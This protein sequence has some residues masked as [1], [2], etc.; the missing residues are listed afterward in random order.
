MKRSL[1]AL[2]LLL[3]VSAIASAQTGLEINEIFNGKYAGD[4]KVTQT[5]ISG[6]NKF[7]KAHDLTVFATFKGPASKYAPIIE[8]MI[9][10]DG[11]KSVGR[12]IRYKEGKL[13]YVFFML[14]PIMENG[15]KIN[16]FLYY[17]NNQPQKGN[18]MM[19]VYFEG[20]IS[21]NEAN[22]LIQTMAK[23]VK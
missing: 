10:A 19:V 7:L 17:L 6:T 5:M 13:H 23:N 16:R 8:P 14:K 11:A 4:P 9:L 12:N 18:N 1:F 20:D 3:T 15:A 2:M 22:A 21:Q